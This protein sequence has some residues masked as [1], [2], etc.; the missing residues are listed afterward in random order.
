[1]HSRLKRASSARTTEIE[2]LESRLLLT[3]TFAAPVNTPLSTT[4]AATIEIVLGDVNG[5]HI[6]DLIALRQDQTVESFFGAATGHFTAGPLFSSGG[7]ILAA[8]D[9][10]KDGKLDLVT[11]AGVLPGKGD[12]TFSAPISTLAL[13]ATSFNV[14]TGDFNG[15]GNPDIAAG[16]TLPGGG[17]Q[18]SNIGVATLLGNGDG[19]FKALLS[20]TLGPQTTN[21]ST[22]PTL[23]T[24]DF[25]KDGKLDILSPFGVSLGNGDGTFQAPLAL[26]AGA[27]P[28]PSGGAGGAMTGPVLFAVADFNGDGI[29]DVA[30]TQA[31]TSA[32]SVIILLGKGD[33]TFTIGTPAALGAT[34]TLTA[35]D[36][37]DL[38]ADGHADLLVGTGAARAGSGGAPGTGGS[39]LILG[40]NGD[41]TFAAPATVAVTGAPVSLMTADMNGDG[42]PDVVSLAG[43]GTGASVNG[44]LPGLSVDVLLNTSQA[45]SGNP[46]TGGGGGTTTPTG[47]AA[48]TVTLTAAPNETVFGE[49]VQLT[50]RVR[51]AGSPIPTGT[52]SFLDGRIT[53]GTATLNA[54]KATLLTTALGFGAHALTA[55]YSGDASYAAATSAAVS[56]TVLVTTARVPFL[57]FALGATTL[58]NPFLSGDRGTIQ[59]IVQNLGGG[60]ADGSVGVKLFLTQNGTIDASAIPLGV[61]TLFSHVVRLGPGKAE[62]FVVPF[63]TPSVPA[64][65]YIIAAQLVA[66]RRF[67][68]GQVTQ[69]VAVSSTPV[70]AAGDIFGTLGTHSHLTF[71]A[72]DS[73]GHQ[74]VLSLSGPGMGTVTQR[75]S[76]TDVDVTGTTAGSV[77]HIVTRGGAFSFGTIRVSGA[78]ARFDAPGASVTAGLTIQ[79]GAAQVSLGSA[80]GPGPGTSLIIGAGSPS[81]FTLGTLSGVTLQAGTVIRNLTA[82]S[83]TGGAIIAPQIDRL[84]VSGTMSA[85]VY[86]HNGGGIQLVRA[87]AISGGTWAVP[88]GFT[89]L[90]VTGDVSGARI[91]AGADA[92]ADNVLGTADDIYKRAAIGSILIGGNVLSST[93]AAGAV[94]AS[95]TNLSGGFVVQPRSPIFKIKIGGSVSTDTRF[96]AR[97]LPAKV[98]IAGMSVA[99][100]ADPRFAS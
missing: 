62:S 78:L 6:P 15:D 5:D 35:L 41:G 44:L 10:N 2:S 68:A 75:G 91:F 8:A 63:S 12:G 76:V 96:L 40:G 52:V 16:F 65:R 57:T 19:S 89:T 58:T 74:A 13:P 22:F 59:I 9:F 94:P 77:L 79:G 56:E 21:G 69:G 20:T 43:T 34:S 29:P 73:A 42:K 7:L 39:L 82:A 33:G 99:T 32:A 3:A 54:G 83:W 84:T 53:L 95:G 38:D 88:G 60:T 90:R 67:T 11:A 18:P 51:G 80:G 55:S 24:G 92:G 36:A 49:T 14:L 61:R 31:E 72:S 100:S 27:I 64:G 70:Q 66:A 28:T 97:P 23:A 30:V 17:G 47:T 93:I 26:P 71:T 46:G 1:M 98:V 87:G 4:G 86:V 45:G 37:A 81:S 48:S 85:N 50:V 25:N